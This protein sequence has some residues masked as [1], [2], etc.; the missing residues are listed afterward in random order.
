MQFKESQNYKYPKENLFHEFEIK[1]DIINKIK[2]SFV[3]FGYRE[4]C[5][6]VVQSYGTFSLTK[7]TLIENEMIKFID[8]SGEIL[9]LRPD[10]TIPIT[11]IIE[12]NHM[13]PIDKLKLYYC[14]QVFRSNN[15]TNKEEFTQAG[16]EYF[17]DVSIAADAEVIVMAIE[18]LRK[19]DV[20][21]HIEIGHAGFYKA[22]MDK[23]NIS[24]NLENELKTLIE[25]KNFSETERFVECLDIDDNIKDILSEIPNM[26]GDFVQVLEKANRLSLTS[27]M[28]KSLDEVQSLYEILCDYGYDRYISVDLGLLNHLD[29]Y[30]GITFK[31]YLSNYG[32]IIL[33]GGRYDKLAKIDGN[34]IPAT[35][36]G[37]NIDEMLNGIGAD[38]KMLNRNYYTDYLVLY[39]D[40]NRKSAFKIS[41][42]LRENGF[43]VQNDIYNGA[44]KEYIEKAEIY[45][46][47]NIILVAED[48]IKLIDILKNSTLTFDDNICCNCFESMFANRHI[49]SIH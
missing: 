49:A 46:F 22:L 42:Y 9:V 19:C 25:S 45:G 32:Q 20:D 10:T 29:Y 47:K 5:T 27:N 2:E 43:I 26:Y 17:G 31:G 16:V 14:E 11:K 30:T 15:R 34:F 35:G 24:L 28:K 38:K 4:I 3:S 12:N 36:F 39:I 7:C 48:K 23:I 8:K 21:F 44:L 13:S 41:Q 1:K 18:S 40:E 33:N 6:S 37:V